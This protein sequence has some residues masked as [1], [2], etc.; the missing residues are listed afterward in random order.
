M[1]ERGR[2]KGPV[3]DRFALSGT[4][5]HPSPLDTRSPLLRCFVDLLILSLSFIYSCSSIHSLSHSFTCV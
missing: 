3:K 1:G 2:R 5:S 4:L